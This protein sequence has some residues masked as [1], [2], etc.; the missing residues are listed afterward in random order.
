MGGVTSLSSST[1]TPPDLP[2]FN[3]EDRVKLLVMRRDQRGSVRDCWTWGG[4]RG[5]WTLTRAQSRSQ[6]S[7]RSSWCPTLNTPR[8]S[9]SWWDIFSSLSPSTC[10]RWKDGAYCCRLSS[11]PEGQRDAREDSCKAEETR[12]QG[13]PERANTAEFR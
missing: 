7:R 12:G 3:P 13:C 2:S 8:D 11:R 4:R 6:A 9:R 1:G 10:C 5:P